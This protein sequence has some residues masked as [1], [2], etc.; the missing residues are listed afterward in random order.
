MPDSWAMVL[1]LLAR[2]RVVIPV[3]ATSRPQVIETP[4]TGVEDERTTMSMYGANPEQ[5]ATS[6]AR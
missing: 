1:P 6:A 3:A 4:P 2:F 5:L